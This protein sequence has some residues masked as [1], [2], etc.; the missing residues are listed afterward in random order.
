MTYAAHPRFS[1]P[2][3]AIEA[4]PPTGTGSERADVCFM[5]IHTNLMRASGLHH[6]QVAVIDRNRKPRLNDLLAVSINGGVIMRRL[7][8][9]AGKFCFVAD[10]PREEI[11]YAEVGVTVERIGVIV[12]VMSDMDGCFQ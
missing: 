6:G 8:K 3:R 7:E 12:D 1:P 2:N 11:F 10:D 9:R 4:R 5:P